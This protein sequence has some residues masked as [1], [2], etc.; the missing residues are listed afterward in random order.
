MLDSKDPLQ[1]AGRVAKEHFLLRIQSSGSRKLGIVE[2][3]GK[4]DMRT[5]QIG[6][7]YRVMME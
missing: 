7:L 6:R 2:L 1:E 4:I 3:P 5:K